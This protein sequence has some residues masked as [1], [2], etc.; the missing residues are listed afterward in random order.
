[1]SKKTFKIISDFRELLCMDTKIP[2]TCAWMSA[3]GSQKAAD[4]NSW[5]TM[6]EVPREELEEKTGLTFDKALPSFKFMYKTIEL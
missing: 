6:A 5:K 3:R 4:A 1:M 2:M